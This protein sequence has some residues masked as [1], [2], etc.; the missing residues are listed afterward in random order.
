MTNEERREVA[1][2]GS[3]SKQ[4]RI[5]A[6]KLVP[7]TA[8]VA[9]SVRGASTPASAMVIWATTCGAMAVAARVAVRH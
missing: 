4:K 7:C 9:R 6:R 1:A 3:Y 8:I 2:T 5:W